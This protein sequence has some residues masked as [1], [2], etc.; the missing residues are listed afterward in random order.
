MRLMR[1]FAR[2]SVS[3]WMCALSVAGATALLQ[4]EPKPCHDTVVRPV[5][6]ASSNAMCLAPQPDRRVQAAAGVAG[7]VGTWVALGAA[8]RLLTSFET[9]RQLA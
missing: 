3:A 1:A 8:G 7:G 5:G 9:R 4:D 2:L 6:L